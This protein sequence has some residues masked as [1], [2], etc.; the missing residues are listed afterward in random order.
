MEGNNM[1]EEIT[2]EGICCGLRVGDTVPDFKLTTY[3]PATGGFGEVSLEAL[4]AQGKWTVLVFYPA[5][6]TF[7]CATE[8]EA[9]A[10][11]YDAFKKAGA[12]VITVSTDTQFT[13]LAWQRDEKSLKNVKYP[14]GADANAA[15]S[16]LF[17]VYNECTGLDFRG[18][19]IISPDGV[20][21]NAEVN[22]YNLGRNMDELLRKV[23]A[24]AYLAK[25]GEQAC[26]AKWGKEGDKTLTP[27]A[28]LVGKVFEALQ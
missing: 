13:H 1:G 26:P 9:L 22:F 12:E 7:V 8:F 17:N 19:F 4:K 16:R 2:M 15:V 24:N 25:H 23:Q 21:L 20:L 14:M 28:D 10:E 18:S 5:D 3:E 11:K 27:G 6:F